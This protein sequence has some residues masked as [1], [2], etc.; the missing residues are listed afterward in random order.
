MKPA[1]WR[2]DTLP[3]PGARKPSHGISRRHARREH[4]PAAPTR[5][6][7]IGADQRLRHVSTN[8]LAGLLETVAAAPF[9][10][11]AD[12][13]EVAD[14]VQLDADELLPA[15]EALHL[16]GLAELASGD[17]VLTPTGRDY[18]TA[19]TQERKQIFSRQL[20]ACVPLVA[21]IRHVL[22][23]RPQQAAPRIRFEAELQD[24]LSDDD[25]S[26]TLDTAIEW[27]RY[28]ELFA[29]DDQSGRF[30]LED[31]TA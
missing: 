7:G 6:A 3:A 20:L 28:A 27:G 17:I 10:G 1:A 21:H 2:W 13:P 24:R 26:E 22:T 12:L 15:A 31:V 4:G 16:L 23:S 18:A 30:S 9:D 29:Y 11:R 25:A 14:D 5:P 19:G 8:I